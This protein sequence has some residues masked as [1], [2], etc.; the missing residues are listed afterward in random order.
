MM[1]SGEIRLSTMTMRRMPV[2]A[3]SRDPL[4]PV[5]T[6]ANYVSTAFSAAQSD[7]GISPVVVTATYLSTPNQPGA[8]SPYSLFS[9]PDMGSFMMGGGF[10]GAYAGTTSTLIYMSGIPAAEMSLDAAALPLLGGG[11]GFMGGAVIGAVAYGVISATQG[12][13]PPGFPS[14]TFPPPGDPIGFH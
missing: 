5:V 7:D 12:P 11:L 1:A 13:T 8:Y 2:L 10:V 14:L 9:Q 4:S 3:Q 6:T